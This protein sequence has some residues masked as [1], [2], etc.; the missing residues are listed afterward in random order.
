MADHLDSVTGLTFGALFPASAGPLSD[1]LT[2]F[3]HTGAI[4]G[5]VTVTEAQETANGA[6]FTYIINQNWADPMQ[7]VSPSALTEP[8]GANSDVFGVTNGAV[9]GCTFMNGCLGFESDTETVSPGTE[10]TI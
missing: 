10:G 5:Q 6:G 1:S 2:V 8:G 4:M 9:A 7:Q 3:D